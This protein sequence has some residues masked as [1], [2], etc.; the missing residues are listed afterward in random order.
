ACPDG[1]A[2]VTGRRSPQG[3]G[4]VGSWW[5]AGRRR[6]KTVFTARL[7]MADSAPSTAASR[8]AVPGRAFPSASRTPAAASHSRLWS[9]ALAGAGPLD[10]GPQSER[11]PLHPG[12][13][14]LA[15]ADR[16]HLGLGEVHELH[17]H[18]AAAEETVAQQR[19]ELHAAEPVLLRPLARH[20]S[21][22]VVGDDQ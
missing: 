7:V 19:V 4:P 5:S 20:R 21:G 1:K 12:H 18:R 6:P 8:T 17:P 13:R 3:S 11:P 10:G 14:L 9:A 22:L 15:G 2:L 16:Q